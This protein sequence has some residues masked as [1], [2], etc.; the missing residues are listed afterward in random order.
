MLIN[1]S[2][3]QTRQF[4]SGFG[5]TP[6]LLISMGHVVPET[7]RSAR[8]RKKRT[9]YAARRKRQW[10]KLQP[11]EKLRKIGREQS[12]RIRENLTDGYVRAVLSRQLNVPA[13]EITQAQVEEKRRNLHAKRLRW[14][15]TPNEN[16]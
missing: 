8:G 1:I 3:P 12:A 5:I 14:A 9:N 10:R 7:A 13:S 6:E 15:T 16:H 4:L 2:N 11:V